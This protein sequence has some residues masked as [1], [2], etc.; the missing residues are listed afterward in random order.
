MF[1]VNIDERQNKVIIKLEEDFNLPQ[2]QELLLWIEQMSANLKKGFSVLT[3]MSTLKKMDINTRKPVEKTMDLLNRRGVSKVVRVIPDNT[4][5]I[6]FNIMSQFHYSKEV[7]IFTCGSLE[8]AEKFLS[9]SI[10]LSKEQNN[11]RKE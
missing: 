5:D 9:N 2:A 4:K 10:L 11:S 8:E 3:D 7:S 6:G 1:K